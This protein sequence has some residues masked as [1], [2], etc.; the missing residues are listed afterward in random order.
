MIRSSPHCWLKRAAAVLTLVG[1][2]ML[3]TPASAQVALLPGGSVVPNTFDPT[4]TVLDSVS[5][6]F[7]AATF[8]GTLVSAVV[9]NANGTLDFYYQV[10]ND[11][12][13]GTSLDRISTINFAGFDTEVFYRTDD[14]DGLTGDPFTT[15]G[16]QAPSIADRGDELLVQEVGFNF[17]PLTADRVNPGEWTHVLGVRTNATRYVPGLTSVI[18]GGTADIV[19]FAP[20]SAVP[21]PMSASLLIGGLLPIGLG[22]FRRRFKKDEGAS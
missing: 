18:D 3:A 6:P 22:A 10:C 21:E 4:G 12:T 8:S 17:G 9:L 19:T 16:N 20:A 11:A 7:S 1:T 5:T 2:V 13:S 15:I 14:G